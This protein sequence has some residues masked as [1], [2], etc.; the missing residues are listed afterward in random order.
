M[1]SATKTIPDV[2]TDDPSAP[3][4][5]WL[6]GVYVTA[7]SRGGCAPGQNCDIFIQQDESY[8]DLTDA[9]QK[10]LRIGVAPNAADHFTG[11]AVGDKVDVF[12]YAFRNTQDG[13]NELFILVSQSLPGCA[14]VVGSGNPTPVPATLDELT[15]AGYE[16]NGPALVT[17]SDVSGKPHMPGET[18]ALW[19]TATGPMGTITD[20]TSMSPFC[21]PNQAF[22]GFTPETIVDFTSVT[23]VF[24]VFAPPAMPLI[25]YE[26]IYIRDMSEAPLAP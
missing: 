13:M 4:P 8:A 10:G 24:A 25:K 11:I 5:I 21:L 9:Q 6:P 1:G 16:A 3:T 22:V 23:G 18:F 14:K 17:V 2:W 20:V 7:L 12:G 26:E 19:D 15:T